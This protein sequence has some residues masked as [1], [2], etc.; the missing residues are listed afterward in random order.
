MRAP[1]A[2]LLLA[3]GLPALSLFSAAAGQFEDAATAYTNGDYATAMRLMRPLADQGNDN[4]Q[5][6]LGVIN[7][8]GLGVPQDYA[9]ALAWYRKAADQ[10]FA[11]AQYNIGVMYD[12]G[13]G[14]PQ[15]YAQAIAWFR[16]AA[17]QGFAAAQYNIAKL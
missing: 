14:V 8:N 2:K 15:D 11:A 13:Q 17:D 6:N 9:Q 12:L 7:A 1:R 3:V 10:G 16:K 5:Y 4:A